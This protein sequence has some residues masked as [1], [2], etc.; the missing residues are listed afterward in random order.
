MITNR[1]LSTIHLTCI[2]SPIPMETSNISPEKRRLKASNG[3]VSNLER[4]CLS[5]KPTRKTPCHWSFKSL[6]VQSWKRDLG[7]KRLKH[8]DHI[9]HCKLFCALLMESSETVDVDVM[10]LIWVVF[11]DLFTTKTPKND[12]RIRISLTHRLGVPN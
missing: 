2:K 10:D 9:S 7:R 5:G 12:M 1:P 6:R 3:W 11:R 8:T 4:C